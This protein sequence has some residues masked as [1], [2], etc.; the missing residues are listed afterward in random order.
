M[1]LDTVDPEL[2]LARGRYATVNSEY[3]T[4][5][6]IIQSWTQQACDSL[7]HGLQESNLDLAIGEFEYAEE[8]ASKLKIAIQEAAELKAQKD[9]LYR[10]AWGK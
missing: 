4:Q 5:M 6:A 8:L 7:R 10:A 1:N 9:E 3:K 2:I